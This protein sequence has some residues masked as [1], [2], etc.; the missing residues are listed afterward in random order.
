MNATRQLKVT[1]N[2]P[3]TMRYQARLHSCANGNHYG[4]KHTEI[5][6]MGTKFRRCEYCKEL[7]K[8]V[9]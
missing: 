7:Y 4:L 8:L 2:E 1:V 6:I 5:D 3:L 9:V